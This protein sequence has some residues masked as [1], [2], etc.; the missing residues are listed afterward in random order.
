M[1]NTALESVEA[2]GK[3]WGSPPAGGVLPSEGNGLGNF[4][5]SA[6]SPRPRCADERMPARVD[7]S[8]LIDQLDQRPNVRGS[9]SSASAAGSC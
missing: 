1:E 9:S 3:E 4:S 5:G 7:F 6:L 2:R 8:G